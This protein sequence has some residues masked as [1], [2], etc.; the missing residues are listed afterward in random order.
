[1]TTAAPPAG[2]PDVIVV[3]AGTAGLSAAKRLTEAGLE[4]LVLE[5]GDHVGGRCVTDASAFSVPFDRGASWLH[6]APINPLARL[7]EER[8]ETLHKT[9]WRW[10]WAHDRGRS[11]TSAELADYNA[12]QG[13]MWDH[14]NAAGA[15]GRDRPVI[16]ALPASPHKPMAKHWVAQMLGGDAERASCADVRQYADA[17]GDWL[18]AGGLGAFIRRLHDG[19]NV[20]LSAPVTKIDYAGAGVRVATPAGTV[21]ASHLVL[22]VSTGVLAAGTIEFFPPLPE[23]KRRAVEMLPNG[24][25]NKIGLEFDPDW[26]EARQGQVA[27]YA[28]GDGEFC[29][30]LFGFFDTPLAVGFL[31]GDF[32]AEV[33]Q[34]GEG[35]ATDYCLEALTAVFGGDVGK[36][37][38]RTAETAWRGD[39][40]TRGS[41]SFASV[42]GA[43]ARAILA[44]PLA[45]RIFFAGEATST[46]AYSTVHGAYESGVAAAE[47]II[48]LATGEG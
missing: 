2:D 28:S 26:N 25:L 1:M 36:R 39:P 42:G 12:Y 5:A 45:G 35:A 3:G 14:V 6:S 18:V 10:A 41:Y 48:G 47:A 4:T 15:G 11:L 19:V 44:E 29:T 33:E 46:T 22:T 21:A 31:A 30:I 32:A 40:L 9:P 24:L 27:D 8:G 17:E 34:A 20:R 13:E 16:D 43:P 23:R 37:V 7:A 38:R